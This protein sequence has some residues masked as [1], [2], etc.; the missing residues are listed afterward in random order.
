[1]A[2]ARA[3]ALPEEER[4]PT[5]GELDGEDPMKETRWMRGCELKLACKDRISS[6]VLELEI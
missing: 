3:S 1:M 2:K 5:D 4:L 6:G